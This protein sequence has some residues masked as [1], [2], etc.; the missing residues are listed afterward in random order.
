MRMIFLPVLTSV[1]TIRLSCINGFPIYIKNVSK[2]I[3][4]LFFMT[5]V[6]FFGDLNVIGYS[7]KEFV[8]YLCFNKIPEVPLIAV[9]FRCE[10]FHD[11]VQNKRC[12]RLA[13][14]GRIEFEKNTLMQYPKQCLNTG[15]RFFFPTNKREASICKLIVVLFFVLLFLSS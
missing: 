7:I 4:F 8:M 12:T 5:F 14:G 11:E 6:L 1:D 10:M 3:L 13:V 2:P 9:S 15:V